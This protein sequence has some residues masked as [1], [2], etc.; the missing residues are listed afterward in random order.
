MASGCSC[1]SALQQGGSTTA[2]VS[3]VGQAPDARD[4]KAVTE[5]STSTEDEARMKSIEE[6]RADLLAMPPSW[7]EIERL[8]RS[9]SS[10]QAERAKLIEE[11]NGIHALRQAQVSRPD[12]EL[13]REPRASLWARLLDFQ[14]Y[15]C[16]SRRSV[17][18]K[19][20]PA[21]PRMGTPLPKVLATESRQAT[22]MTQDAS[23]PSGSASSAGGG[24]AY[25]QELLWETLRHVPNTVA[26][27]C[28]I[29]DLQVLCVSGTAEALGLAARPGANLV[30]L[31]TSS[32]RAAWIRKCV[33]AHQG[34]AEDDWG[35]IP[36]FLVRNLGVEDFVVP[37][38]VFRSELI[39]IHL[40][41]DDK[42]YGASLLA[43]LQPVSDKAQ[44]QWPIQV[45]SP[46]CG[47]PRC[48]MDEYSV[49]ASDSISQVF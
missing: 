45:S 29:P 15:R 49:T 10:L 33:D 18:S 1:S 14:H 35:G 23:A 2:S 24:S 40:P 47:S 13:L 4:V 39:T 42:G 43:L 38:G 30:S 26:L 22:P 25:G 44:L 37:T 32:D 34:L 41:A 20:P 5:S 9:N 8:K 12:R 16:R 48:M 46:Q 36:G 11:L 31:L 3:S 28:K 7:E 27:L 6:L 17:E 21:M 19:E